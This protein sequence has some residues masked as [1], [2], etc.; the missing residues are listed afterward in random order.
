MTGEVVLANDELNAGLKG[1]GIAGGLSFVLLGII[2]GVGIRSWRIISVIFTM[3]LMGVVLT[4]AFA[5][6]AIGGYNVLSL[7]FVVM[8]FGLGVDFA[9]HFALRVREA[10]AATGPEDASIV[11]AR[12]IGPA[13]ALCMLTTMIAFLSFSPTAYRG[14]AE[15][16]VISAGGMV[17]AFTLTLTLLPAMFSLLGISSKE[18]PKMVFNRLISIDLKINP[19]IILVTVVGL[20]LIAFN[21]ARDIKFDYSVLAMRDASTEGMTTLLDLQRDKISTDY[22]ISVLAKDPESAEI[23]KEA[24][25]ELSVVGEVSTP[26]DFIPEAQAQKKEKLEALL[27]LYHN[28]EEILPAESTEGLSDALQYMDESI[29]QVRDSDKHLVDF[30]RSGLT[31]IVDDEETLTR[32]NL[33]LFEQLNIEL[34]SLKKMLAASPFTID[35]VPADLR[36]SMITSAG[37]H[38][39]TVHPAK[40]LTSRQKTEEFIDEVSSVAPNIA[41]R[42]VV[43][44]GIGGVV[45]ESFIFAGTGS[46]IAIFLLLLVYF[47]NFVLPL[48]VFVPIFLSILFTFAI[49]QLT[50]ISLNMANIL[51][52]PL[53]IGL[54]VD[55]GIHVVHRYTHSNSVESLYTSSTARAVLISAL[56]TIGTFFSLSF[57]PHKGA[58]SVGLLLT[59]AISL[60]ILATFVVLPALL[61]VSRIGNKADSIS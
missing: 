41:G 60:L 16:G 48:F 27:E 52:V 23:L 32:L 19:S 51:V 54:G 10:A 45:V 15:L 31:D 36:K 13:L 46:L 5:T 11:A 18:M 44:W 38:L 58:A 1:I 61:R 33:Q 40:P 28:I 34:K 39:L 56:T 21:F 24:L 30:L 9:V 57:S 59:I 49:C 29:T 4:M 43:E 55:T 3:L 25:K 17:V 7:I 35:A 37:E 2:L 26:H 12:D 6:L 14:L 42:S 22:S 47:R 20:S 8:F 53:I 50:G